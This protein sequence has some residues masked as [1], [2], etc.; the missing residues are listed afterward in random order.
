MRIVLAERAMT[1]KRN[2]LSSFS[3]KALFSVLLITLLGIQ[4]LD[5]PHE[6]TEAV[7]P[8]GYWVIVISLALAAGFIAFVEA[9]QRRFPHDNLFAVADLILGR[10]L[11]LIGN[12]LFLLD[13]LGWMVLTMREGIDL[14]SLLSLRNT[15]YMLTTLLFLM[16]LAYAALKGSVAVWRL[17]AVMLIPVMALRVL[18]GSM[19]LQ[20]VQPSYLLPVFSARAG[21]YLLG[22]LRF[23]S[24]FVP[25]VAVLLLYNRLSEPR[26]LGGTLFLA[27]FGATAVTV[28]ELIGS[29]GTFGASYVQRFN[30]PTLASMRTISY[31]YL[32]L[33]QSGLLFTVV[34]GTMLFAACAFYATLAA[35]GV[36][37]TFP[38]IGY[39]WAAGGLLAVVLVGILAFHDAFVARNAFRVFRHYAAIP[40][41]AYPLFVYLLAVLRGKKGE[42]L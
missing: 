28:L 36:R 25:L 32:I 4:F 2:E 30:W 22:S 35:E 40:V 5:T 9:F 8:S 15:P 18:L 37:Q 34:W 27:A 41:V 3:P 19:M 33:E 20:N 39:P 7:G 23:S 26:R 10:P 31:P 29:V 13:F 17:A 38:P 42:T 21:D 14:V 11:A 6:A 24:T 1:V 16:P 12:S